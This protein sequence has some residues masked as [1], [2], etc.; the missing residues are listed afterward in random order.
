MREGLAWFERVCP[1]RIVRR[2][3]V[4]RR[5]LRKAVPEGATEPSYFVPG[6]QGG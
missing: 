2:I 6:I 1:P 5:A 4:V 3:R